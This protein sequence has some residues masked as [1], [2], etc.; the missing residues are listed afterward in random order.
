M[1]K[2]KIAQYLSNFSRFC[3]GQIVGR[4]VGTSG[5]KLH[6]GPKG[7][8]N[9]ILLKDCAETGSS[10]VTYFE[11]GSLGFATQEKLNLSYLHGKADDRA[12]ATSP[13]AG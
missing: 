12:E 9:R 11:Y 5:R 8:S 4:T 7:F 3:L 2:G 1:R 6:M 13:G 10:Y